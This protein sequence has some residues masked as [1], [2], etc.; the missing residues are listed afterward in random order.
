[1]DV[2]FVLGGEAANV[3]AKGLMSLG[4][5]SYQPLMVFYRGATR[6]LLSDFKG[7][8]LEIG[9]AGSGT[10]SL[11]L[12]LLKLNGI[13][14]GDGTVLL[15][16]VAGN[17]VK[18]LLDNQVDALFVMGDST[19]TDLLRQL[20]HTP[21]IH[22]FNFAQADA[23][24][25]RVSYLNKLTLPRGGLDLGKDI[26]ETDTQLIGP[27]VELIAREGLHPALSDLLLEAAREV[28]GKPGCSRKR[29]SFRYWLSMK[30]AS[31]RMPSVTTPPA[32]PA[33]PY[34]PLLAGRAGGP[35]SGGHPAA[36]AVAD[37]GTE[38]GPGHLPLAHP[39]RH[40]PLV[41][42]VVR[43]RARGGGTAYRAGQAGGIAAPAGPCG[44][45]RQQDRGAG[46]LWR[47][48]VRAARP[49]R[50]CPQPLAGR[51]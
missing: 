3:D 8:R 7:Q 37:T 34:L 31:A 50:L 2:G 23:Y 6:P 29:E 22:L 35:R 45:H 10:H 11:A 18:A 16:T 17:A 40:Q 43:Y 27:T 39:V 12:A 21:D 41:S 42:G 5:I 26:P 47:F 25:R 32:K 4:S 19:S 49:Y 20:L 46:G 33:V 28:H 1:V 15:D 51:C 24:A 14:P 44:C 48:V 38:S 36:G 30:S 13:T 9:E